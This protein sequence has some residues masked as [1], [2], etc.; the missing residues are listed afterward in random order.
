[1]SDTMSFVVRCKNYFGLLPG[2]TIRDF[3]AE[4]KALTPE[5][6]AEF[7]SLFNAIGLPTAPPK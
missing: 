2:K 3:S 4:L 7:C 1:M 5:D 6:K